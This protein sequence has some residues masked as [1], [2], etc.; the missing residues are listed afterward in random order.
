MAAVIGREVK[1][2]KQD[3]RLTWIDEETGVA[4]DI[5]LCK[6]FHDSIDLLG[7]ARKGD[8]H[9]QPAK[10]DVERDASKVEIAHVR[11]KSSG[12]EI[13]STGKQEGLSTQGKPISPR[14][15]EEREGR[16]LA[17]RRE[18]V[19]DLVSRHDLLQPLQPELGTLFFFSQRHVGRL[20]LP[21]RL[22]R[23]RSRSSPVRPA[24]TD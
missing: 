24:S 12:V 15:L 2:E 18:D 8:V 17:P 13:V 11:S 1:R 20:F 4:L 21:L 6:R 16:G 3:R 14:M 19:R 7:L 10:G 23:C 9:K 5:L 22:L